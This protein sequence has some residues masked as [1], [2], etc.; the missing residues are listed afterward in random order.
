[1]EVNTYNFGDTIL[2][3]DQMGAVEDKY[4]VPEIPVVIES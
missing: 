1:M 4:C 3:C 2:G